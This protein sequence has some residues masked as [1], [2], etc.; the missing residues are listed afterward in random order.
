MEA[1]QL[2]GKVT[3]GRRRSGY[4]AVI[5]IDIVSLWIVHHLLP[6]GWPPFLTDRFADLLPIIDVS[7]VATIA[8]NA[9]WIGHDPDWLRHLAQIGLNGI[10]FVAAARTW[11]VFPFDFGTGP[12]ETVAR[13]MLVVAFFGVVGGTIAEAVQ[14]A[15]SVVSPGPCPPERVRPPA[16]T[17]PGAPAR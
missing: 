1:K 5:L 8:V 13:V 2:D 3:R 14:L 9:V 6:W 15:R 17:G 11:Q 12:W 10:A 16:R 7:L 4:V